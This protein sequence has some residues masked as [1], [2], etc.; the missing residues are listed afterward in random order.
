[1]L[2]Q[3]CARETSP[4]KGSETILVRNSCEQVEREIRGDKKEE[5]FVDEISNSAG[6]K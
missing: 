4:K 2:D 3:A 5:Y 6:Q 1:M